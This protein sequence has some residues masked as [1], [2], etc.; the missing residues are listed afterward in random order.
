MTTNATPARRGAKAP[1]I[2]N[3]APEIPNKGPEIPEVAS[4]QVVLPEATAPVQRLTLV[5]WAWTNH[6]NYKAGADG[7]KSRMYFSLKYRTRENVDVITEVH[8]FGAQADFLAN[9]L[10]HNTQVVARGRFEAKP[11]GDDPTKIEQVFI[12]ND[13]YGLTLPI[14]K[15]K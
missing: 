12:L 15:K 7:R 1:E 10:V 3:E 9:N 4:G 2:P 11:R 6:Q 8:A 13:A 14:P 5:G